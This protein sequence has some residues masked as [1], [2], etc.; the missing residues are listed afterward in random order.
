M[1]TN[2]SH[3]VST[4]GVFVE[5]RDEEEEEGRRRRRDEGGGEEELKRCDVSFYRTR[6]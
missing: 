4:A 1:Y 3:P 6:I 2:M 5:K